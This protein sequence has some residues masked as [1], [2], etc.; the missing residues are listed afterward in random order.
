MEAQRF[1]SLVRVVATRSRREA[2]LALL[3]GAL[4]LSGLYQAEAGMM[5][6]G[7]GKKRRKRR[8]KNRSS[9]KKKNTCR[10]AP[11]EAVF[12]DSRAE[13]FCWVTVQGRKPFCGTV[14]NPAS[15]GDC[16]RCAVGETC[17]DTAGTGIECGPATGCVQPCPAPR[18]NRCCRGASRR[19]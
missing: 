7:K 12:C 8:R 1:D 11:T 10:S 2:L 13:C 9:C 5:G 4:G 3:G 17:V 18:K 15:R 19:R 14:P 6:M 16:S